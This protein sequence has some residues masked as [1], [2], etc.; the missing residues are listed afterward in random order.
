MIQKGQKVPV[1][2]LNSQIVD[3]C[4]GWNV[5]NSDCDV[6]VSAFLLNDTGSQKIFWHLRRIVIIVHVLS[7][8]ELFHRKVY[9]RQRLQGEEVMR[10][11][12]SFQMEIR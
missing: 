7:E 3:V 8:V 6:D 5:N 2:L 9:L 4:M 1:S 12:H 10:M 11:W